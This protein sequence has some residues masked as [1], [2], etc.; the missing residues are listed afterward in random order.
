MKNI[1]GCSAFIV[2][3]CSFF[4]YLS[5]ISRI[6]EGVI[7]FSFESGFSLKEFGYSIYYSIVTFTSLGYGDIHPLGWSHVIASIEVILGVFFMSLFVVVFVR[8]MSR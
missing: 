1:V 4:Y 5:G 8:K 2:F 6:G 3:L 7:K